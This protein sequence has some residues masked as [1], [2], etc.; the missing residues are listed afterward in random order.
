MAKTQQTT[1]AQEPETIPQEPK[2][3]VETKSEEPKLVPIYISSK[4]IE[5]L[6]ERAPGERTLQYVRGDV[7]GQPFK[8]ECDR[9]VLA[10]PH[11]AEA[12]S[13]LIERQKAQR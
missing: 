8:V 6:S 10:Q 3:Q 13:G 5:T 11:V 1:D 4:G 2:I 9:Q 12:L 7:N